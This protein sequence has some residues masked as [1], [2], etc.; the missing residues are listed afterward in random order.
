MRGIPD[1]WIERLAIALAMLGA[2]VGLAVLVAPAPAQCFIDPYS[3][4]QICRPPGDGW[5]PPASLPP[6]R[7]QRYVFDAPPPA[8]SAARPLAWRCRIATDVGAM[9]SGSLIAADLVL[10]AN[11]VV[12]D[13]RGP[14]TVAFPSGQRVAGVVVARD[15]QYDLAA[16]RI[17]AVGIAPAATDTRD[18]SGPLIAGGFGGD[19]QFRVVEG[20]ITG[21]VT[22]SSAPGG[23]PC[24]KIAGAVRPG[25][26]GGGVVNQSRVLVGVL[27][28]EASGETYLTC[29]APLRRFL[30]R[31]LPLPPPAPSPQ[32][33]A[34]PQ[35]DQTWAPVAPPPQPSES[36]DRPTAPTTPAPAPPAPQVPAVA[37][38][39]PRPPAAI[40]EGQFSDLPAQAPPAGASPPAGTGKTAG[41]VEAIGGLLG[42]IGLGSWIALGTTLIG[43]PAGFAAGVAAAF[44]FRRLKRK[45]QTPTR[46]L[47]RAP[48][49]PHPP[50]APPS[51]IVVDAPPTPPEILPE[52]RYVTVE[53]NKF[54]QAYAWAA[55]QTGRKWPGQTE[56]LVALDS[57]IQQKLNA[58]P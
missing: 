34:A 28:G 15:P 12:R 47:D 45:V 58:M 19:G 9:G 32:P 51:P 11:H 29:G 1:Y 21:Y 14:V 18:P 7:G 22:Y 39:P 52:I 31:L 5:Q 36:P 3:G 4:Q 33:P 42:S 37:P 57:L 53:G 24:P 48:A 44:A 55:D 54:A 13:S 43:G 8:T 38:T 35:G 56:V 30:A 25:D 6:E 2:L 16:I 26:S 23:D 10:T 27:W 50:F 49:C 46:R 20:P 17:A 41:V 40:S